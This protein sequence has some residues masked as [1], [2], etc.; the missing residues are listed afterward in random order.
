MS[1][2]KKRGDGG[3]GGLMKRSDTVIKIVSALLFLA[4][5][6]Y[7]GVYIFEAMRDP[8]YTTL[9]VETEVRRTGA[10]SGIVVREEYALTNRR[11]YCSI[12]ARDGSRVAV[13]SVLAIAYDSEV[14]LQRA[15]RTRELQL[16]IEFAES[17]LRGHGVPEDPSDYDA[18]IRAAVR[19]LSVDVARHELGLID[20]RSLNLRSL[21]FE[22]SA[23]AVSQTELDAMRRELMSLQ[24]SSTA[25]TLILTAETSGL[26]SSLLDGYEHLAPADLAGLDTES[27]RA[28]MRDRREPASAAY[29]KLITAYEW[30][31]CALVNAET[32]AQLVTGTHYALEFGRHYGRS[33][34]MKLVSLS[35][36]D[37]GGQCAAVFSC[38]RAMADTLAMRAISAEIALE[39]FSGLRVPYEAVHVEEGQACVYTVTGLV[40]ERKAINIIMDTGEFFLVEPDALRAGN[41]II[42]GGQDLYDGKVLD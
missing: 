24:N 34:D 12:A 18:A 41:D 30:Y 15:N 29:G 11:T 31:Y 8:L 37:V 6:A 38:T 26:F 14:A 33:L 28:L 40:A 35:A 2:T 9:A 17:T 1:F 4:V 39:E 25:D 10:A 22:S 3:P 5:L 16:E 27:L 23:V 20:V 13:G 32:A 19:A 7:M 36:A 21:L 42:V